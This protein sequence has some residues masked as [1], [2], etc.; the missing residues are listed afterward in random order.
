MVSVPFC[1]KLEM[2]DVILCCHTLPPACW[3]REAKALILWLTV[4]RMAKEGLLSVCA[5]LL[6]KLVSG[7]NPRC[8]A[9]RSRIQAHRQSVVFVSLVS[10]QHRGKTTGWWRLGPWAVVGGCFVVG[11]SL[12]FSPPSDCVSLPSTMTWAPCPHGVRTLKKK[13]GSKCGLPAKAQSVMQSGS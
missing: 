2:S 5:F 8:H 11:F 9:L 13:V 12:S 4:L 1:T 3:E 7:A 6:P 10:P